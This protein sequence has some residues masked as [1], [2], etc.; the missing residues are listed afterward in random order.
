MPTAN[1]EDAD[2]PREAGLRKGL[3]NICGVSG[4]AHNALNVQSTGIQP[5]RP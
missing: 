1:R 4:M 2:T 3:S 5:F